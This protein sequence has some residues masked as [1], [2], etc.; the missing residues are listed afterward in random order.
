[1]T[2][3]EK[4]DSLFVVV[5]GE[6]VVLLGEEAELKKAEKGLHAVLEGPNI[7]TVGGVDSYFGQPLFAKVPAGTV[8]G[9]L[10]G[11]GLYEERNATVC[12]GPQ[13]AGVTVL[14]VKSETVE[15]L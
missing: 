7:A 11:L 13:E 1:M 5:E 12:A 6:L 2:R 15:K 4:G 10:A 3:G 9:E 8:L 14:E